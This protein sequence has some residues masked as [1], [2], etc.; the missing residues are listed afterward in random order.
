MQKAIRLRT[1]R[2]DSSARLALKKYN[3]ERAEFFYK[4]VSNCALLL[5]CLVRQECTI[6]NVY[7]ILSNI[8][9]LLFLC[10]IFVCRE[11]LAKL[12]IIRAKKGEVQKKRFDSLLRSLEAESRYWVTPENMDTKITEELFNKPCTTGVVTKSSEFWRNYARCTNINRL[13]FGVLP[14]MKDEDTINDVILE[15]TQAERATKEDIMGTLNSMIG[16]GEDREK[17]DEL[18]ED[19]STFTGSVG[20]TNRKPVNFNVTP[21][22]DKMKKDDFLNLFEK[23]ENEYEDKLLHDKIDDLMESSGQATASTSSAMDD[24]SDNDDLHISEN[25][26]HMDEE[27]LPTLVNEESTVRKVKELDEGDVFMEE[28]EEGAYASAEPSMLDSLI[29]DLEYMDEDNEEALFNAYEKIKK[30]MMNKN[31]I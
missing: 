26:F 20:G 13:L 6:A 5:S 19:F 12:K 10:Y 9:P 11:H 31:R 15:R 3:N 22:F 2:E 14:N 1:K 27:V 24:D 30:N 25:D 7:N 28:E 17:F 8:L 21:D 16:T 29:E 23:G 18:V 4:Y